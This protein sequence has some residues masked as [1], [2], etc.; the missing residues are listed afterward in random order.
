MN[1]PPLTLVQSLIAAYPGKRCWGIQVTFLYHIIISYST[2]SLQFY[3][4]RHYQK[5]VWYAPSTHGHSKPGIYRSH[6]CPHTRGARGR[7]VVRSQWQDLPSFGVFVFD[8]LRS[9]PRVIGAVARR[10]SLERSRRMVRFMSILYVFELV[11]YD[12]Q[13][14]EL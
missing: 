2:I 11:A 4:R 12:T 8:G 6:R 13:L 10:N 3:R 9:L 7:K 1:K 5:R 14:L